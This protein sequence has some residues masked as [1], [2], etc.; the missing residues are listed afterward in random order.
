[1]RA[2]CVKQIQKHDQARAKVIWLTGLVTMTL[3]SNIDFVRAFVTW[4]KSERILKL[5]ELGQDVYSIIENV[6]WWEQIW[7]RKKNAKAS[8]LALV[9]ENYRR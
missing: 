1:M 9:S 2:V 5:T 4:F 3:Q 6:V 8:K 7:K